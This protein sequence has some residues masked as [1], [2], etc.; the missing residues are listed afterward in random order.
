M[1]CIY[2]AQIEHPQYNNRAISNLPS[3]GRENVLSH[4]VY[5][6]RYN[7]SFPS[8]HADKSTEPSVILFFIPLIEYLKL[9]LQHTIRDLILR[10][11]T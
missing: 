10:Q 1:T 11:Q 7:I 6:S 3:G 5:R 2:I 4:I 9:P 8:M